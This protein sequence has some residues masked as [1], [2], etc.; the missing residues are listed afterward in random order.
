MQNS[1]QAA[2]NSCWKLLLQID[3]KLAG[4]DGG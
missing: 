2:E 1:D 3:V 4:V